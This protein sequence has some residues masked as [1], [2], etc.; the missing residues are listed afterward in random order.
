V[1]NDDGFEPFWL[2]EKDWLVAIAVLSG[3]E[4]G[5]DDLEDL[6]WIGRVFG[7]AQVT[8]TRMLALVG[9]PE[10]PAYELLFSFD[11]EENKRRFLEL[12][13]LDGYA[14]PD[15]EGAF[16]IPDYSEIRD[17]RPLGAVFPEKQAEFIAQVGT[18]TVIGLETDATNSDA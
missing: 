15:E 2:D 13:K 3:E 16:T 7:F 12:V 9:D 11:S 5:E 6:N 8:N 14:D 1:A 10:G 18:I 17:A 4:V